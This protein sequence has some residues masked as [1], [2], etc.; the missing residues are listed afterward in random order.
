MSAVLFIEFLIFFSEILLRKNKYFSRKYFFQNSAPLVS[1][2]WSLLTI[3]A[4]YEAKIAKICYFW[5]FRL[6]IQLIKHIFKIRQKAFLPN[7]P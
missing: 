1:A 7:G 2:Y 5:T 6:V 3:L 4:R